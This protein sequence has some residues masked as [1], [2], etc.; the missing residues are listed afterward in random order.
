MLLPFSWAVSSSGHHLHFM[1][2]FRRLCSAPFSFSSICFLQFV[3]NTHSN[4]SV[5]CLLFAAFCTPRPSASLR[6]RLSRTASF[7]IG[8]LPLEVVL[9]R[10]SW[11]GPFGE[12][13]TWQD[14]ER[15]R[16]HRVAEF[17]SVG[18]FDCRW[19]AYLQPKKARE[20]GRVNLPFNGHGPS[21]ST[22][23]DSSARL[24]GAGADPISGL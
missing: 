20:A 15:E 11:I 1:L 6:A 7:A 5:Y 12:A 10:Q 17:T 14:V 3:V 9:S 19:S 4:F 13:T 22:H 21:C 24:V 8:L 2:E 18:Q 16:A 23:S